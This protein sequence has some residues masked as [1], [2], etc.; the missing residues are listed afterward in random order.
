[1]ANFRD[2]GNGLLDIHN[3]SINGSPQIFMCFSL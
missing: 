2:V 1:M 3:Q